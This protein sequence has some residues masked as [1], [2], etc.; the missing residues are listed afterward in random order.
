MFLCGANCIKLS[1][2]DRMPRINPILIMTMLRSCRQ[3]KQVMVWRKAWLATSVPTRILTAEEI[4]TCRHRASRERSWNE[5]RY[6]SDKCRAQG[7][8]A[9]RAGAGGAGTG[10][11]AGAGEE[12]AGEGGSAGRREEGGSG[13][14]AGSSKGDVN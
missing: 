6:C 11:G 8:K 3:C 10:A 14:P 4:L 12:G 2:C 1:C 5:V 7:K 13:S 9:A